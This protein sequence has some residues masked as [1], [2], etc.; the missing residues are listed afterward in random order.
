[1]SIS[2]ELVGAEDLLA[3]TSK[4]KMHLQTPYVATSLLRITLLPRVHDEFDI[5]FAHF[6]EQRIHTTRPRNQ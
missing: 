1:M 2:R 4:D 5:I 6:C 3:N